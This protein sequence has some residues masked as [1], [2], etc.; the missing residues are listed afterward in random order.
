VTKRIRMQEA[1]RK[2]TAKNSHASD[3]STGKCQEKQRPLNTNISGSTQDANK[4]DIS[5]RKEGNR[6]GRETI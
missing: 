4:K 5:T 1:G 2:A 3:S 6:R